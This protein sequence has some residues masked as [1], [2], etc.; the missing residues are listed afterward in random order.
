M[1]VSNTIYSL[2]TYANPIPGATFYAYYI[3]NILIITRIGPSSVILNGLKADN[4]P[5]R[6]KVVAQTPCGTVSTNGLDGSYIASCSGS[7]SVTQR[8]AN[9]SEVLSTETE[10]SPTAN[11]TQINVY[12]NPAGNTV[13]ITIPP[14][15]IART[16]IK[17]YDLMGRLLNK[18][19]P[20]SHTTNINIANFSG[21]VYIVEVSDG[22]ISVKK[23]IIKE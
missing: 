13:S 20:V 6:L 19:T 9:V 18:T 22:I 17:L 10:T 21:G 7:G 12:P 3:D 1:C 11:S 2:G 16:T 4:K 8:V 14:D 15:L 23:K 5:H